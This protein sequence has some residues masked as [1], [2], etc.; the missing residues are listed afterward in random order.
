MFPQV[1]IDKPHVVHFLF[2]EF[3]YVRKK[4]W[5]VT[6][7][8]S[9][10]EMMTFFQYTHGRDDVLGTE[11]AHLTKVKSSC[12]MPFIPCEFMKYQLSQVILLLAFIYHLAT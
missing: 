3:G 6:I 7:D 9:T 4:M 2:S 1:D 8:M 5:L 12:P 11:G 10:K